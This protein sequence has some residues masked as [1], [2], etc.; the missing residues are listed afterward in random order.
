[1]FK[2]RFYVFPE[3]VEQYKNGISEIGTI[4][5][6]YEYECFEN[7]IIMPL[8]RNLNL[9]KPWEGTY[10]EGGVF[11]KDLQPLATY[12]TSIK[13]KSYV[14]TPGFGARTV[15]CEP[16]GEIKQSDKVV[17]WVGFIMDH[18]GHFITDSLARLWYTVKYSSDQN[19]IAFLIY[20][21][22]VNNESNSFDTLKA[23]HI[24]LLSLLGVT[25]ERILLVDE[26]TQFRQVIVPKQ[27]VYWHD[28]YNHDLLR[29]VY[30]KILENITPKK[31]K[32]IYLSRS[33][34]DECSFN[35]QYFENFFEQH[36]FKI[37]YPEQMTVQEQI[38][39]LAGADEVAATVGTLT[40]QILFAKDNIKLIGL[41]RTH[42]SMLDRQ[43]IINKI[44]NADF[45]Y[46]DVSINL[47]P[48]PRHWNVAYL[49]GPNH[50]WNDFLK[51][52]YGLENCIDLVEYLNNNN[53]L[54]GNYIKTYIKYLLRDKL[55]LI[56]YDKSSISDDYF[57]SLFISFDSNNEHYEQLLRAL[58]TKIINKVSSFN[59]KLFKLIT[60]DEVYQESIIKL[61]QSRVIYVL[62]GHVNSLPRYWILFENDLCLLNGRQECLIKF[63]LT[64]QRYN[65]VSE[66]GYYGQLSSQSNIIYRLLPIEETEYQNEIKSFNTKY[67]TVRLIIK[68][69]VNKKKYKKFKRDPYLFFSDSQ[70][71]IIKYL[72]RYLD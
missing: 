35:E 12:N 66:S 68:L 22:V 59:N 72:G 16:I 5:Y 47:F 26:P 61:D 70:S 53:I 18:Y 36:G 54:L 33:K 24:E 11:G 14:C 46:I 71:P 60:N 37:I 29:L 20:K 28:T 48:V 19:K 6:E 41:L 13:S 69:L 43:G 57:K 27:A 56:N 25:Q 67:N 8:R 30:D 9:Y 31:F 1:M 38:S 45:V 2:S 44:K 34:F 39:Y 23:Y 52:E 51:N 21:H 50:F 64:N 49:I 10:L 7:A 40:H 17:I 55:N 58:N 62:S 65:M 63:D 3:L 42:K 32:K 15:P 4:D